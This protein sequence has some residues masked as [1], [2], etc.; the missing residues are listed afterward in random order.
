VRVR[1]LWWAIGGAATAV[2]VQRA[3]V[4]QWRG[5]G[6]AFEDAE[7][8]HGEHHVLR[9]GAAAPLVAER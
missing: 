3:V 9:P 2:V 5:L 8:P 7:D 4:A 6:E 1:R